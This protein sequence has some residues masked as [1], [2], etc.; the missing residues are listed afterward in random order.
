MLFL[1]CDENGRE[2]YRARSR[3]LADSVAAREGGCVVEVGC[4]HCGGELA[5]FSPSGRGVAACDDCQ[6]VWESAA[7]LAADQDAAAA[8]R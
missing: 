7:D 2:M 3:N 8:R 1:I 6:L 5:A 4:P